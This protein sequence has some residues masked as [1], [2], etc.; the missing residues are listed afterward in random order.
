MDDP[1]CKSALQRIESLGHNL[2]IIIGAIIRKETKYKLKKIIIN[3][4]ALKQPYIVFKKSK[5]EENGLP[6]M[7]RCTFK[8]SE[9]S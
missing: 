1:I 5:K 2:L 6:V 8:V 4:L 3:L 9:P 7:Q